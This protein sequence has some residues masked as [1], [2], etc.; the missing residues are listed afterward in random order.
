MGHAKQS[1]ALIE[2]DAITEQIYL[3]RGRKVMLDTE[4]AKLYEVKTFRLNEAVKR[5]NRR[6][7]RR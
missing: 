7:D 2:E 5:N 4:L 3:I 1:T 6:S